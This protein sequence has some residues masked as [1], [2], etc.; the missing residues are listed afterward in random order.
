MRSLTQLCVRL[1]LQW[2]LPSGTRKSERCFDSSARSPGRSRV[3]RCRQKKRSWCTCAKVC[4]VTYKISWR[5]SGR[6]SVKFR[7]D[8]ST[9]HLLCRRKSKNLL[10]FMSTSTNFSR[11]Q[12]KN[13]G[14]GKHTFGCIARQSLTTV[15][16]APGDSHTPISDSYKRSW[17][18][19]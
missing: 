9:R 15:R 7:G 13:T 10:F 12:W 1:G 16:K 11:F 3:S 18:A 8:R 5:Q 19:R 17:G 4:R 14:D 6:W 2:L